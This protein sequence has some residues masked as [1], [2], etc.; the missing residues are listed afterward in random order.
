M[1]GFVVDEAD[2]HGRRLDW[3]LGYGPDDGGGRVGLRSCVPDVVGV[4]ERN[5]EGIF[6]DSSLV[7]DAAR[8]NMAVVGPTRGTDSDDM[9]GGVVDEGIDGN[10]NRSH[11]HGDD[12]P[13]NGNGSGAGRFAN[14]LAVI[15]IVERCRCGVGVGVDAAC[16]AAESV[17][18]GVWGIENAVQRTTI[19]DETRSGS[20]TTNAILCNGK[21]D[22][23]GSGGAVRPSAVIVARRVIERGGGG[24]NAGGGSGRVAKLVVT[25][26]LGRNTALLGTVVD[27][28]SYGDGLIGG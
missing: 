14:P 23:L 2:I 13:G 1:D 18:G 20:R 19:V 15:R 28:A 26:K 12:G 22:L 7:G 27:E 25:R 17:V 9:I 5:G 6:A 4:V 8:G 21:G 3:R 16:I 11:W 10:E 24:I